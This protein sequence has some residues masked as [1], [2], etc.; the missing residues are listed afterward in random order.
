M[1]FVTEIVC[2]VRRAIAEIGAGL[3]GFLADTQAFGAAQLAHFER[4]A[5]H[6]VGVFSGRKV[7]EQELAEALDVGGKLPATSV[8]HGAVDQ[9]GQCARQLPEQVA[10]R[11][12]A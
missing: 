4:H 5:V 6:E 3:L 1:K 12:E 11:V 10:F 2:L 7:S 8:K 9:S